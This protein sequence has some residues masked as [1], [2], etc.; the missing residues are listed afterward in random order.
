MAKEKKID[1]GYYIDINLLA[2]HRYES[3]LSS[4]EREQYFRE[5]GLPPRAVTSENHDNAYNKI[6]ETMACIEKEK[7]CDR[8]RVFKRGEKEILPELIYDSSKDKKEKN[9][10]ELIME[11]RNQN[12]TELLKNP[13]TYLNR[14]QSLKE[15]VRKKGIPE[16]MKKIEKLEEEFLRELEQ[17]LEGPEL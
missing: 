5:T 14:I 3:L 12:K 15:R 7:L 11:A 1:G 4:Y 2:V 8:I 17:S 10:K 9:I 16:Q 6:L 13:K